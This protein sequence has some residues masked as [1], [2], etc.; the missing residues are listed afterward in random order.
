M[1]GICSEKLVPWDMNVEWPYASTADSMMSESDLP[2]YEGWLLSIDESIYLQETCWKSFEIEFQP[3]LLYKQGG[4]ILGA[5]R[6]QLKDQL[7]R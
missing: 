7:C 4:V 5:N 6:G 2:G 3:E 1:G